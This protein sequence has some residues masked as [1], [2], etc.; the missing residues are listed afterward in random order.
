MIPIPIDSG[1]YIAQKSQTDSLS[2]GD[3]FGN[4]N[5]DGLFNLI[6]MGIYNQYCAVWDR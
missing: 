1:S 4:K 5:T 3:G 2:L 6:L